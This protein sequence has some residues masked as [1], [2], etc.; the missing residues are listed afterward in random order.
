ML[1]MRQK[2]AVTKEMI[3]RY[4]RARKIKKIDMLNEF[5]N[6]TGYNRSYGSRILRGDYRPVKNKM[7]NR[8]SVV[9]DID[10]LDAL[11]KVW[12]IAD[13]ICG[14]RLAPF[15]PELLD[16]LVQQKEIRVNKTIYRK[17]T[18][19]SASTID[20]LLKNTKKR[21]QLKGRST[22]KPGSLLKHQVPIRTFSDW[23]ESVP[24][25]FE[26]D[27]VA[28]CGNSVAGE[29]VN[30][31]NITDIKTAWMEFEAVL[32]KAQFRV[33]AALKRR[34]EQCPINW[35]G[36]DSDGGSE[37]IN[38][39]LVRYSVQEKLTFTR[40]RPYRKNDQNYI[41]Q[42]NYSVIRRVL[43][44]A[45]YDT[46][47]ELL[48]INKILTLYRLYVNFFQ[49]VVRM[50]E[51]TRTGAKITRIYKKALTPYRRVLACD[52][53]LQSTKERLTKLYDKLNPADL[54]RQIELL[55]INLDNI[56]K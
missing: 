27:C 2:Q 22:T 17:L 29:F 41:E 40:S 5:C 44:Y 15:L 12:V 37:F 16:K 42:K 21:Y 52:E 31:L 46:Q 13:G 32:G 33:F 50:E 4:D 43:G 30:T 55:R 8:R 34:R 24:G 6:L 45:R 1:T 19:I 38:D 48:I 3:K 9:Y 28:N 51:K 56:K 7:V 25:F 10:V 14:K 26:I 47:E 23:N 54:K 36:F 11:T 53:I 20:R 49:P 39:E 35:L 18:Q